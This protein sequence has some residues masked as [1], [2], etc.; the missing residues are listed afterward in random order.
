[1]AVS[2]SAAIRA[3]TPTARPKSATATQDRPTARIAPLTSS[4]SDLTKPGGQARATAPSISWVSTNGCPAI[5]GTLPWVPPRTRTTTQSISTCATPCRATCQ[6]SRW[7]RRLRR[8][9]GIRTML[10]KIGAALAVV[11]MVAL[12]AAA[13]GL[14]NAGGAT[15]PYPMYSKWF[16]DYKVK[17][18]V[19]INYQSK[20]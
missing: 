10:K 13:Q 5:R 11:G 20:G 2:T 1:M 14:I 18:G 8:K 17:T 6:T 7:D 16:N 3:W 15:F 4:R 19:A 9:K 12:G